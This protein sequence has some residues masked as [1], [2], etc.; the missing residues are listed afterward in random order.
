MF[1]ASDLDALTYLKELGKVKNATRGTCVLGRTA[2]RVSSRR[3]GGDE[4]AKSDAITYRRGR[5]SDLRD[6]VD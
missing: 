2:F 6:E 4:S 1:F 5:V 3:V